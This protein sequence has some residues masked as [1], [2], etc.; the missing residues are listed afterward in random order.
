MVSM[1]T[2]AQMQAIVDAMQEDDVILGD[3]WDRLPACEHTGKVLSPTQ[4][5]EFCRWYSKDNTGLSLD[6]T[7]AI[8]VF[9][10]KVL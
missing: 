9:E 10:P 3:F 1:F 2:K 6:I 5:I 4:W 8:E 7:E